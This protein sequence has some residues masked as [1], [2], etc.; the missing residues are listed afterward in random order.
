MPLCRTVCVAVLLCAWG[1]HAR[2]QEA[3]LPVSGIGTSIP[4]VYGDASGV[5]VATTVTSIAY[6]LPVRVRRDHVELLEV[7]G[8]IKGVG[9]GGEWQMPG[10]PNPIVDVTS[11]YSY[12][13]PFVLRWHPAF[14]GTLIYYSHGRASLSLLLLAESV[15]GEANEGRRNEREGDFIA[16]AMLE[17]SR[18]HAFFAANLSGLK[19]DGSFSMRALDGPFAGEPLAGTVDAVTARDLARAGKHLMEVLTGKPVKTTVGMGHSAGALIAQFLDS[20]QSM[21]LDEDRF[22]TRLLTGGDFNTPYEPASG[23]IFDA[24]VAL[25]P[26]EV[27]VNRAQPLAAPMLMIAGQAEFAGVNS[28]LYARRVA[29]AGGDLGLLRVYQVRNLPHNFAEIVESTPNL[30]QMFADLF[31]AAPQADGDRMKPVIAAV[32]DRAVDWAARGTPA[33]AS[34]I[35]GK[36]VDLD[37]DGL[38]DALAFPYANGGFT[39]AVPAVD[40]STLDRYDG[41]T[42]DTAFDI[43][44]SRYLE[45]LAGMVYDPAA[46]SLPFE[47]CRLGGFVISEAFSDS[48]FVPFTNM[49]ERWKSFGDYRACL[50]S[51]L[52]AL[53]Q[54]GLYDVAYAPDAARAK[55]LIK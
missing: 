49:A 20:G 55:A 42:A 1:A 36:G 43:V 14:D 53:S 5:S 39:T 16:S 6:T 2:A 30:N 15:I 47:T 40:D 4:D 48:T 50:A 52:T 51:Q 41:F 29:R 12:D 23:R 45:P 22:G 31:G 21:I 3:V 19:K 37:G 44:T 24:F 54:T 34:R 7:T 17:G 8:S 28:L 25:A 13:I 26:S 11:H 27:T 35:E 18:R 10:G 32:L 33:P 46:L 9:W 38:T